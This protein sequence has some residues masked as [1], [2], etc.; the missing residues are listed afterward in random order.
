MKLKKRLVIKIIKLSLKMLL[1]LAVFGIFYAS[2]KAVIENKNI[3]KEI[4]DFKNRA[5]FVSEENYIYRPGVI[6]KRRYYEVSRET[7]YE[8]ADTRNVFTHENKKV[9]GQ[10]G[11]IF[12]AQESPFPAIFG[13]HHFITYYTGGHAA[14]HDGIN[15]FIEATGF[16]EGDDTALKI[17]LHR[18]Q[19]PHNFNVTAKNTQFNYWLEPQFRNEDSIEYPRYGT[20]YR[21]KFIVLRVKNITEEQI[22]QAV[23][24]AMDKVNVGLY[25]FLFMIDMKYKFYCTDL[26]SRAYQEALVEPQRRS[27]Y[28]RSLNDDG[29]VTSVND[30][31]LSKETY[32]V[33]YVE[34]IDHVF[35]IYYLKDSINEGSE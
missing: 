14:I 1:I 22:D 11:D 30:L 20:Y 26:V 9:L 10:K 25:N 8:L 28:S 24:Y 19:N 16:P 18:G 27:D 34:V 13:V 4:E 3:N 23:D 7:S 12:V 29:F 17:I 32:I 5:V 33:S 6:Q 2:G 35:H 31:I 15:G 21:N